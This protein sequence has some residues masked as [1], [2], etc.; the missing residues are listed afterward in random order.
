MTHFNVNVL[1]RMLFRSRKILWWWKK[2]RK[3]QDIR[4]ATIRATTTKKRKL[5]VVFRLFRYVSMKPFSAFTFVEIFTVKKQPDSTLIRLKLDEFRYAI[6]NGWV[7][8]KNHKWPIRMNENFERSLFFGCF[9]WNNQSNG[10]FYV[11]LSR[12]TVTQCFLFSF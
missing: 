1:F 10:L 3:F 7:A 2:S 5:V 6:T 11:W 9:D 8:D 12:L 4:F